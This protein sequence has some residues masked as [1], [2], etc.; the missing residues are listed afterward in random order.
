MFGFTKNWFES[1][2]RY[3]IGNTKRIKLAVIGTPSSGKSYLL[4][5]IIHS[6]S[7]LGFKRGEL[8]LSFPFSSFAGYFNDISDPNG[9]VGGTV[10]YA[11]RQENHYGAMLYGGCDGQKVDIEFV[12]IPGEVFSTDQTSISTFFM[13]RD[14]IKRTAKGVFTVTT[15]QAFDGEKCYVVEPSDGVRQKN[16]LPVSDKSSTVAINESAYKMSYGEWPQIYSKLNRRQY[17]EVPGSRRDVNGKY[18]INH[19]FELM[20]D[21]LMQT[22]KEAWPSFVNGNMKVTQEAFINNKLD[23]DFYFHMFC[24][25]AT[26]II[27]CDKLFSQGEV[28]SEEE[29]A[30]AQNFSQ[31][32]QLINQFLEGNK[33]RPNI[34]LAFRGADMMMDEEKVKQIKSQLKD[35]REDERNNAIYS[36]FLHDVCEYLGTQ[37]N[38]PSPINPWIGLRPTED[39][40]ALTSDFVNTDCTALTGLDIKRHIESRLG[41]MASGFWM[42]L[43]TVSDRNRVNVE[44]NRPNKLP[45]PPHVYFTSTPIDDSYDIYEAD[46]ENKN[47]RFVHKEG[48]KVVSFNVVGR[49]LC[50]GTFQLCTDLLVQ[51]GVNPGAFRVG[52]LLRKLQI[53]LK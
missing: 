19:F 11:C 17:Q 51:N 13:L 40:D 16:G 35:Y 2:L 24:Q 48:D 4:S 39:A 36:Y 49:P 28:T 7:L 22:I 5:D 26:D 23:R 50:F 1:F 12:N 34:Y 37:G 33:A 45:I 47:Q 46:S 52:A 10:T 38:H 20:P 21:S 31:M 9:C 42:L 15:W 18:I 6:F 41:T 30:A 3:K 53:N 29:Q 44:Y 43:N 32:T 27:I 25:D 14:S 8:P